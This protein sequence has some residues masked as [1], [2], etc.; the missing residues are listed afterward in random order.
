MLSFRTGN[1]TRTALEAMSDGQLAEPQDSYNT[2]V[3][4]LYNPF[5][6]IGH[7][8]R[9]YRNWKAYG[10]MDE[11]LRLMVL[12]KRKRLYLVC[13]IE[14]SGK[15]IFSDYLQ[16]QEGYKVL[17]TDEIPLDLHKFLHGQDV[18]LCTYGMGIEKE[19]AMAQDIKKRMHILEKWVIME[20]FFRIYE[21]LRQLDGIVVDGTFINSES[22]RMLLESERKFGLRLSS[23]AYWMDTGLEECIRRYRNRNDHISG[24]CIEEMKPLFLTEDNIRENYRLAAPPT[25]KEGFDNVFYV[26]GIS[27]QEFSMTKT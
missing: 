15:S 12:P 17:K 26:R 22:R 2:I 8:I 19:F 10:P 23:D 11:K 24:R 21:N 14:C 16:E 6:W 5:N 27:P 7:A 1:E 3:K 20:S 4:P 9:R 25:K 18:D 13:G